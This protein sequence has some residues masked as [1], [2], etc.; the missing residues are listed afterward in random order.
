LHFILELAESYKKIRR[1]VFNNI[2]IQTVKFNNANLREN[3]FKKVFSDAFIPKVKTEQLGNICYMSVGMVTNADE[4]TSQGEFS[5]DDLIS[6]V[7]DT[8]HPQPYVEGKNIKAYCITKVRYIEY[9]NGRVPEKL[10]RPTFRQLYSSEKI[11]RGRVTP[12]V[13]DN[14]G[15][16]CNDSIIV[17]KRF[18]ELKGV[19]E[20]SIT[21]SISKNN[22][23]EAER[24]KTGRVKKISTNKKRTELEKKSEQF[25]LKYILA[26]LNSKYA[27][28][29]LNNF[30]RHR[31]ENYFYPDDFRNLP[32]PLLSPQSQK[33]FI[34]IVCLVL[35]LKSEGKD[36]TALEQQIDNLVY[37]LYELTYQEVKII[38][39]EFKLTESEYEAIK[40][41]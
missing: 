26:I 36:T 25:S 29:Y 15:I 35:S 34:D 23:D 19:E 41:E 14:K 37:K 39:P 30:R 10:R 1:T 22:L 4:L 21:T 27:F 18:I 31:L 16:V 11:L 24:V 20:L 17:M 9:N 32:I 28:A 8:N 12:A 40:I 38:D 13:I 2:E 7:Q 5:K 6:D 3:I 33:K